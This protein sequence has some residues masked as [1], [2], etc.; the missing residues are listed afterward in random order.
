[1][2]FFIIV[3]CTSTTIVQQMIENLH[4]CVQVEWKILLALRKK[5]MHL[6]K[7]ACVKSST[8]SCA[9][10]ERLASLVFRLR[11]T[12]SRAFSTRYSRFALVAYF[13]QTVLNR[14]FD[15]DYEKVGPFGAQSSP[16]G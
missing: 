2:L 14:V 16:L 7:C 13:S 5:Y 9:S 10:G 11:Q 1:M 12:R 15:K 4:A 3:L 6:C 8:A